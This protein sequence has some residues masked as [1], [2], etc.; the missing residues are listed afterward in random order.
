M[1][2]I[3]PKEIRPYISLGEDG[4]WEHSEDMPSEL[5]ETFERFVEELNKAK[6]LKQNMDLMD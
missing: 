4:Q 3:P 5:E 6:D 1:M 2:I